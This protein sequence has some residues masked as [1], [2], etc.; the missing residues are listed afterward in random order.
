MRKTILFWKIYERMAT[1]CN[2]L[3]I[4]GLTTNFGDEGLEKKKPNQTISNREEPNNFA[5]KTKHEETDFNRAE[6]K[7]CDQ[8]G[9][10]KNLGQHRQEEHRN[11]KYFK[12][13]CP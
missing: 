4:A 1:K 7:N 12:S 2:E 9:L 11:S 6:T 13:L 8:Y 3:K 10:E 5:V